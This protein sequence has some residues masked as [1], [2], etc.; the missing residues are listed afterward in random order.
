MI[1][2]GIDKV[3]RQSGRN[4]LRHLPFSI[5]QV[6]GDIPRQIIRDQRE[7]L[8]FGAGQVV[9]D[10][11]TGL[12][13]DGSIQDNFAA[14]PLSRCNLGCNDH[15]ILAWGQNI[16]WLKGELEAVVVDN[17]T[18]EDDVAFIV[19]VQPIGA[20]FLQ[21]LTKG[22]SESIAQARFDCLVEERVDLDRAF[23]G[24]HAVGGTEVIASTA[25]DEN[26]E[27]VAE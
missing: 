19:R 23:T 21:I 12:A 14:E 10:E 3:K 24:G 20:V 9:P 18:A 1:D 25:G 17:R 27:L 5:H 22:H 15:P 7:E 11:K 13:G 8:P 6:G 16:S 2:E 4:R 26:A